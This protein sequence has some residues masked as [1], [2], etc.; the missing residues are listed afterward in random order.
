MSTTM[1]EPVVSNRSLQLESMASSFTQSVH[2]RSM[3]EEDML[4]SEESDLALPLRQALAFE[5]LLNEQ[6]VFIQEEEQI[7]GGQTLYR[8][9]TV[10]QG[11]WSFQ[12]L[13]EP[14]FPQYAIE[15][16]CSKGCCS[17]ANG[18][19]YVPNNA[20]IL[21]RGLG[22]VDE[23]VGFHLDR[24]PSP[25]HR[26]YW[27]SA[28]Q[29]IS[30][31][32][33][34]IIRYADLCETL[35]NKCSDEAR[36]KELSEMERRCEIAARQAPKDLPAALQLM[37]FLQF[38]TS[39]EENV[40]LG[41]LVDT[42]RPYWN[43]SIEQMGMT[44]QEGFEWIHQFLIKVC[45]QDNRKVAVE[46]QFDPTAAHEG[47]SLD[48]AISL[49]VRRLQELGQPFSLRCIPVE[50]RDLSTCPARLGHV[51][52]GTGLERLFCGVN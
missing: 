47:D 1:E 11:L 19:T 27:Q 43:H 16:E 32:E 49:S 10:G 7:V 37:A 44:P 41:N 38:F 8:S 40:G 46:L 3:D 24:C 2:H 22:D 23:F 39:L 20:W 34:F 15:G 31:M 42:L 45:S 5:S 51:D 9:K 12:T 52:F 29:A 13:S 6:S 14:F 26:D 21:G 17:M 28:Q 25:S 35:S 50:Q 4:L 33:S 36:R 30:A 18:S 48:Y